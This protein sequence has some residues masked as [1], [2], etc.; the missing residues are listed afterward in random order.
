MRLLLALMAVIAL[1]CQ[2]KEALSLKAAADQ[3]IWKLHTLE[4]QCTSFQIEPSLIVSA[5]HC[6]NAD[7]FIFRNGEDA[8]E[9]ILIGVSPT[10][11][12]ALF[13]VPGADRP[14]FRVSEAVPE[15]GDT[16][17]AIG[18]P[19]RLSNRLNFAQVRVINVSRDEETDGLYAI[20][21]GP[22]VWPGMSGGPLINAKGEVVGVVS[23]TSQLFFGSATNPTSLLRETGNYAVDL[24]NVINKI[25]ADAAARAPKEEGEP[26]SESLS[27]A[28]E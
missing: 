18:F 6:A 8:L 16:V 22:D 25:I 14:G 15:Y 1:G 10:T 11:D 17:T 21:I 26:E 7:F 27:G 9:G 5:A 23:S 12:I 19:A 20:S 24:Y 3:N 13:Y 28:S 2:P 4:A